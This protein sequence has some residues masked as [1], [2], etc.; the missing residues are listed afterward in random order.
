M[1]KPV[2]T[3]RLSS[4]LSLKHDKGLVPTPF[5]NLRIWSGSGREDVASEVEPPLQVPIRSSVSCVSLNALFCSRE[6]TI[7]KQSDSHLNHCSCGSWKKLILLLLEVECVYLPEDNN[8]FTL[9]YV[10]LISAMIS[11]ETNNTCRK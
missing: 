6:C 4:C 11:I 8:C 1:G 3:V 2:R 10:Q 9:R 7:S 5:S